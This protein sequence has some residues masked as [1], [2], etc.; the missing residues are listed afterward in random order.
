MRQS[1]SALDTG[2]ER[3]VME[4]FSVWELAWLVGQRIRKVQMPEVWWGI[5][6]SVN[7]SANELGEGERWVCSYDEKRKG[8]KYYGWD[9]SALTVQLASEKD[10]FLK[11]KKKQNRNKQTNKKQC[12]FPGSGQGDHTPSRLSYWRQLETMDRTHGA[13]VWEFQKVSG[14]RQLRE[15]DQNSQCHQIG[16]PRES[17]GSREAAAAVRQKP[18]TLMEET[19]PF[20]TE[21][22]WYQKHGKTSHCSFLSV[23]PLLGLRCRHSPGSC[24]A[25]LRGPGARPQKVIMCQ[26]DH[27]EKE[28]K[29]VIP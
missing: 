15:G 12:E 29:T 18:K 26:V 8:S 17:S 21:E 10:V 24:M 13:A 5:K 9:F 2:P 11:F 6:Y 14:S 1:H 16:T 7:R 4:R 19:P 27:R 3:Q 22:L 28:I 23:L 25:A 20:W